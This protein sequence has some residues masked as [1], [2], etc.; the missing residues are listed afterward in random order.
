[1]RLYT[2]TGDDGTTGMFGGLRV[3]KD[4]VRVEAYGTIDELNA[5]VGVARSLALPDDVDRLLAQ[6]Q[7]DLFCLGAELACAPGAE[8]R[9]RSRKIGPDEVL[10]LE[11]AIDGAESELAPLRTF[12][13]P[14]GSKGAA[15]LH[16]ARTVC[17]RAER[18]VIRAG[19]EQPVRDLLVVYLNRLS[20]AL[21][22]LA[23]L[24]NQRAGEPD[25]PW[26]GG[27]GG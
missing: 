5:V 1:M 24:C 4:A 10:A 14:G 25:V 6:I 23:R 7:D 19:R 17:R 8:D 15:A 18:M 22:A 26:R 3:P 16:H 2:K 13:L 9:L 27:L 20:D 11:A 12:V 21:F